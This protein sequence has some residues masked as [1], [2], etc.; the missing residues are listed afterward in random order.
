MSFTKPNKVFYE[1]KKAVESGIPADL[2]RKGNIDDTIVNLVDF[3]NSLE[4]YATTSSCSG[5]IIV[6]RNVSIRPLSFLKL[7]ICFVL[8]S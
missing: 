7:Y 4:D 3:I 8:Q 5:R 6:F 1:R 2:S